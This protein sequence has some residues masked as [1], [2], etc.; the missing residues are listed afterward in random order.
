MN[1]YLFDTGS[2]LGHHHLDHLGR[3]LDTPTTWRLQRLGLEPETRCLELGAGSGSIANWLAGR[4]R[5]VVAVDIDTA[6]LTDVAP[7]VQVIRHDLRDGLPVDGPF[8]LIHAR[9][10]LL[11]LPEREQIL[12]EL[13]EALAPGGHLVLGDITDRPLEAVAVPEPADRDLWNKM[14]HLSHHVVSPARGVSWTWA[15]ETAGRMVTAGLVDVDVMEY[16][17]TTAGGTDG[18]LLHRNLNQQAEPLLLAAGATEPE[19]T[20]YRDLMTNPAFRAWFYEFLVT[21]GRRPR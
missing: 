20:R 6:Q 13:V 9:L 7:G 11:H 19:L 18:C 15:R 8:D 21:S 5:E 14:L 1:D 10:L 3:L 4:T 2:E 17:Q 16:S 12:D